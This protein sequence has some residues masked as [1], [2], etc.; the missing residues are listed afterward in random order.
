MYLFYSIPWN[1][2]RIQENIFVNFYQRIR[3]EEYL[4]ACTE[5]QVWG[6]LILNKTNN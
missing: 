6:H 5:P 1:I 2:G 3:L 4:A